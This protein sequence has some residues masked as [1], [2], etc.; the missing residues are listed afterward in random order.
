MNA[1]TDGLYGVDAHNHGKGSDLEQQANDVGCYVWYADSNVLQIDLDD[2]TSLN[3][4]HMQIGRL[5]AQSDLIDRVEMLRSRNNHYHVIVYLTK[6]LSVAERVALQACL[7]SDPVREIICL[8]RH[9]KGC[10]RPIRLF[11]PFD[12]GEALP[13]DVTL[14][15]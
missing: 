14:V 1:T 10:E 6:S 7:G 5:R 13:T 3:L 9:W 11:R 12:G 15:E 4:L 2:E 8:L